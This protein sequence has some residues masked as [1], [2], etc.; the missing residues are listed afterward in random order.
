MVFPKVPATTNYAIKESAIGTEL[1][2]F[3]LC[4]F[5]KVARV[6]IS[7]QRYCVFSY[8]KEDPNDIL[9]I[10]SNDQAIIGVNSSIR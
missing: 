6:N 7:G 4:F 9:M 3:T 10:I 2:K 8:A 1:S 5:A